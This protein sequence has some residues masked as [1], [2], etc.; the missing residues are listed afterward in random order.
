MKL[1]SAF[2]IGL[3]FGLGLIVAGMTN[4]AKVQAFLDLDGAWDP[5]LALVMAGA[6]AAA[7]PAFALIRRRN[8][9]LL[10]GVLQLPSAHTIDRRLLGGSAVFGIGW[11]MAGV[12][13]GPS[14]V[15]LGTGT[16]QAVLFVAAMLAGMAVYEWLERRRQAHFSKE[17]GGGGVAA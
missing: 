1:V 5:S 6:I 17:P 12:C 14:M 10:G 8:S 4:P 9:S 11:G 7:M 2:L 13:P 3:V 15:L 16:P